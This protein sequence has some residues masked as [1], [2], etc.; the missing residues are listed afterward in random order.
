ME[1]RGTHWR[2]WRLKYMYIVIFSMF[3][4]ISITILLKVHRKILKK[5]NVSGQN[6]IIGPRPLGGL[7]PGATPIPWIRLWIYLVLHKEDNLNTVGACACTLIQGDPL[8]LWYA[9]FSF[10]RWYKLR[11]GSVRGTQKSC[12]MVRRHQLLF[13]KGAI[14]IK[15]H[16]KRDI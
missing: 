16:N 13:K 15:K 8:P 14:F 11:K 5:F 9:V 7:A 6:K 3:C 2:C 12:Y 4:H 10:L 1:G